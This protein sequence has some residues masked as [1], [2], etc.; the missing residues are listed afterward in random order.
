MTEPARDRGPQPVLVRV[1]PDVAARRTRRSPPARPTRS[2]GSRWP[3]RRGR[4]RG[5]GRSTGLAL[6]GLHAHIGS[7]L[8]E[9]DP[10]RRAARELARLGE[11]PLWDL[12]GGLGVR[13]TEEQPAPPSIE[14]YVAAIVGAAAQGAGCG[15]RLMI[16]PGR[17]LCAN[18]GVT[19]YTVETRQAERLPLGRRRRRDVRQPAA[20]ALRGTLRGARRR[21]LRGLHDCVLAG[22]HCESGDVIVRRR[23]RRSA[24]RRRDRDARHRRLRV[25]DGQQ[26]QR[27]A[28]AAGD[29]LR[30]GDARVV[31]GARRSRT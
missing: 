24:P 14:D 10:F 17:A 4:S 3:R 18:A 1:T 12:G 2:S 19:L 27:R 6:Q 7:Q 11:F 15:G 22:K 8:L 21:P 20:D 31:V 23:A 26:L 13:Y 25:R 30:D 5:P 28:R 9:L 16:E 29:L